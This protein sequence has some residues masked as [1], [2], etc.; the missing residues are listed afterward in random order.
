MLLEIPSLGCGKPG[1]RRTGANPRFVIR[2]R[3][4][5]GFKLYDEQYWAR[6]D[7]ENRIKETTFVSAR[8][9]HLQHAAVD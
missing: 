5:D 2:S 9:P 7:I 4:D 1:R 3:Y 6:G 8:G